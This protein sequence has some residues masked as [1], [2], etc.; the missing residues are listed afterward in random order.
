MFRKAGGLWKEDG[1]IWEFD[2]Y[3]AVWVD[4]L[5][6]FDAILLGR[7]K[8]RN[9]F[10]LKL[11]TSLCVVVAVLI[12]GE[13]FWGIWLFLRLFMARF[14]CFYSSSISPSCLQIFLQ[15]YNSILFRKYFITFN[16]YPGYFFSFVVGVAVAAIKRMKIEL[17]TILFTL[18]C[19][20]K[21]K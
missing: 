10:S 1:R 11:N 3:F 20:S 4:W 16:I 18:Y 13:Y 7:T 15:V 8:G 14:Y 17:N 5:I 6:L 12:G 19:L 9:S 2:L 21:I